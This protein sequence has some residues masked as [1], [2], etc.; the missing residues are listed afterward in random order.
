M[1]K[2]SLAVPRMLTLA[3]LLAAA[4]C[5]SAQQP[6]PTKPIRFVVP[7]PPGGSTDPVAR[8][9]AGKLSE[10]WGQQVLVDN[11][12]G[13]NSVIG[14]EAVAKAPPDGYTILLASTPLLTNPSLVPNLTF[15]TIKD[16]DAVTTIARSRFVLVVHPSLPANNLQE[17]IALAKSRPGQLNYGSSAIGGGMHLATELFDGMAGT[18]M[19]HIPYKGSGPVVTDLIGGQLQLSFQIPIS[20]INQVK[21]GKL[22][23]IAI[24]GE[25]RLASLPQT[26][27]FGE[28]GLPGY[29]MV[30]WY[31]IVAPTGTPKGIINKM[32]R[33]MAAILV[34][35][36]IQENLARQGMEPFI[37]TPDQVAALIRAD[38]AKY[39]K[40]IR[41]ANIKLDQ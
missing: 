30:N 32:S 33:E 5:A 34:L 31:G 26:P 7:F 40:I 15:D 36:E 9:A 38:I 23:A 16:F 2:F 25:T 6:Y 18:K 4:A 27:T 13:G 3:V 12:P 20:V 14:T 8:M 41:T 19:Q 35:P 22:K 28:A 29:D 1:I 24:S 37:S 10:S 17:F 11:R 39:A 21:A